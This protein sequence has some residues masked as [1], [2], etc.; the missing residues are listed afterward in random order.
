MATDKSRKESAIDWF[1]ETVMPLTGKPF[2]DVDEKALGEFKRMD[3]FNDVDG[4]LNSTQHYENRKVVPG[5]ILNVLLI[6]DDTFAPATIV[7][8]VSF[9]LLPASK[10]N[11]RYGNMI[12]TG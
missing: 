7:K 2:S 10:E 5:F 9:S 4:T 12:L 6:A 8:S 11:G 3:V 1:T